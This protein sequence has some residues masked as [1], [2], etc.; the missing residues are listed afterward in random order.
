M[1]VYVC[2]HYFGHVFPKVEDLQAHYESC[3]FKNGPILYTEN[4]LIKLGKSAKEQI[5]NEYYPVRIAPEHSHHRHHNPLHHSTDHTSPVMSNNSNAA[6]SRAYREVEIEAPPVQNT[7][8]FHYYIYEDIPT[9]KTFNLMYS[10]GLDFSVNTLIINSHRNVS[11]FKAFFNPDTFDE[12][13]FKKYSSLYTLFLPEKE[14][15]SFTAFRKNLGNK[16]GI[17]DA[18]AASHNE[19][20]IAATSESDV[21]GKFVWTEIA[22]LVVPASQLMDYPAT[23]TQESYYKR[24]ASKPDRELMQDLT[25]M[26]AEKKKNFKERLLDDV[27]ENRINS[28]HSWMGEIHGT[29]VSIEELQDISQTLDFMMEE[30]EKKKR[31]VRY[32]RNKE[33]E[34][35]KKEIQENRKYNNELR[36]IL[37]QKE[38]KIKQMDEMLEKDKKTART[39]FDRAIK[40]KID[41]CDQVYMNKKREIEQDISINQANQLRLQ[42]QIEQFRGEVDH[43]RTT[44][45]KTRQEYDDACSRMKK[46]EQELSE[47]TLKEKDTMKDV[48]KDS[49]LGIGAPKL[50]DFSCISCKTR[51]KDVVFLPCRHMLKCRACCVNVKEGSTKCDDCK[52]VIQKTM[53]V[54]KVEYKLPFDELLGKK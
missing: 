24:S 36:H 29:P 40:N 38:K 42:L 3:I 11:D 16:I 19:V 52:L 25:R 18:K 26:E 27:K 17:N 28:L 50:S 12:E 8:V 48:F 5:N 34:V 46:L 4:K 53:E 41:E 43:Q 54:K 10:F 23:P 13:Q 45:G 51:N 33:M 37:I 9:T 31:E 14:S 15:E 21:I 44:T 47:L 7:G 30:L 1:S 20:L 32:Q 49:G 2:R 6:S 35:I 39:K 22:F